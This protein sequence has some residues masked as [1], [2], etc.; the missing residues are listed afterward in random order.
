MSKNKQRQLLTVSAAYS[1]TPNMQRITFTVADPSLFSTNRAGQYIKLLFTAQGSTDLSQLSEGEKPLARTYTLRDYNP[2]TQ[3]VTI[4]FVK[5]GCFSKAQMAQDTTIAPEHGGY[6]QHF[7]QHAR[8]GDV[9]SMIGPNAI[10]STKLNADWLL[11]VADMSSLPALSIEISALPAYARGYVVLEL[12]SEDDLPTLNLP[13]AMALTVCIKGKTASIADTVAQ[14]A[15]LNGSPNVWCAGEF[16]TMK[17]VRRYVSDQHNIERNACYFSSYW[18]EGVT[19]D[20]H[21][22]LKRADSEQFN[23]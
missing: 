11:L 7:A 13:P 23:H 18:K 8:S 17:A 15:W 5:H 6:G 21:K 9:I 20:G 12:L 2:V 4:D 19:E 22:I 3:E 1:I 10:K 16:T 14:L